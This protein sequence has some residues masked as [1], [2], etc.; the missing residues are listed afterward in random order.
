[1]SNEEI[2]ASQIQSEFN[3]FILKTWNYYQ[4]KLKN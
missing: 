4:V 1:M 3:L 2:K